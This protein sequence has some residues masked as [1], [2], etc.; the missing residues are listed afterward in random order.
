[1]LFAARKSHF[2]RQMSMI[3]CLAGLFNN[4]VT[5]K[6]SSDWRTDYNAMSQA[7]Q[8]SDYDR[9]ADFAKSAVDKIATVNNPTER[10]IG[11]DQILQEL[12]QLNCKYE[13]QQKYAQQESILR[14]I[15]KAEQAKQD[16]AQSYQITQ[17]KKNLA[18]CLVLQGKDKE[19]EQ[20]SSSPHNLSEGKVA[21]SG[22][23]KDLDLL[24]TANNTDD[25]D[26]I[27]K[28]A[29]KA[30]EES[31][32]VENPTEQ[33]VAFDLLLQQL[34]TA[35]FKYTGGKNYPEEEKMLKLMLQIERAQ[36]SQKPSEPTLFGLGR[37]YASI[38]TLKE[39]VTCLVME[40]KNDE[41]ATYDGQYKEKEAKMMQQVQDFQ[42]SM[43]EQASKSQI[44]TKE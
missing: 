22:W 44:K 16:E 43:Q 13:R 28:Y 12:N 5:A 2:I 30:V 8:F 21:N 4:P 37:N 25:R 41:A 38:S 23:K 26:G 31:L 17:A 10:N 29:S 1:M 33:G 36:E 34:Q 15:L 24:S 39:L 35:K 7:Y 32:A 40:G 6:E 20:Y 11:L 42:K 14:A 3:V 27:Y 18:V 9:A 19:A